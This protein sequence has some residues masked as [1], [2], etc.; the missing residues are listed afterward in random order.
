MAIFSY[1]SKFSKVAMRIAWGCYLNLLWIICSLPIITIGASTTALYYV[2]LKIAEDREGD[3]TQQFFRS[4]KQN[5]KQATVIWLILLAIGIFLG[6]DIYVLVHLRAAASGFPAV[7]WTLILAVVIAACV[8]Y[9]VELIFVFPL[10][11]RVDNTTRAMMINA[12]L[13]GTHYLNCT[14]VVFAIH[15][16][17]A[18]VAIRFFTPILVLGEGLCA[19]ASSYLLSPVIRACSID[20]ELESNE[21]PD[22]IHFTS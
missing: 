13:I 11:A 22:D 16:A 3:L 19:V 6:T 21:T 18:V 14:I 10:L 8:A 2:T 7:F 4:F 1:E 9:T 17:M 5:F 20:P 15:F 12:L